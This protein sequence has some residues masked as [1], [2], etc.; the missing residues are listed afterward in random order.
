MKKLTLLF[1]TILIST[2]ILYSQSYNL[3]DVIYLKNGS[4]IRG[5]LIE[6]VPNQSYKIQTK[7][8]N[9]FV[10]DIKDVLKLTKEEDKNSIFKNQ[11]NFNK[12]T[13]T[14]KTNGYKGYIDGVFGFGLNSG[15]VIGL[16]T[17]NGIL[18]S[19]NLFI[20]LGVGLDRY[21][22][23]TQFNMIPIFLDFKYYFNNNN[24]SPFFNASG[25]YSPSITS[26]NS[27]GIYVN[28]SIGLKIAIPNSSSDINISFGL[29][30]QQNEY[31]YGWRTYDGSGSIYH[32]RIGVSF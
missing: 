26:G 5:V 7:D 9:V 20:G 2:K 10:Y 12:L 29:K 13:Q 28:P 32:F 18:L 3:E 8:G 6:Q 4:I 11:N 17:V 25:G 31:K 30:Y 15:S 23:N 16:Q 22:T 14:S 1:F 27:G 21:N 19:P 24:V